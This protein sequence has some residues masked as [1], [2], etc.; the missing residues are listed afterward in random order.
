MNMAGNSAN[1]LPTNPVNVS[2]DNFGMNSVNLPGANSSLINSDS[3]YNP[4][5]T[6]LLLQEKPG[7]LSDGE[8]NYI[9]VPNIPEKVSIGSDAQSGIIISKSRFDYIFI[10]ITLV[11]GFLI[12]GI[13]IGSIVYAFNKTEVVVPPVV[14]S[15]PATEPTS[16]MNVGAAAYPAQQVLSYPIQISNKEVCARNPRTEFRDG[17][18]FCKDPFFGP[19]C[20]QEKHHE[21]FFAVGDA[22]HS[23]L[24]LDIIDEMPAKGKSFTSE[25]CSTFCLENPECKG[26]VYR[27]N[28]NLPTSE[29]ICTLLKEVVVPKNQTI[30]FSADKDSTIYLLS[31]EDLHFEGRV[32]LAA[33]IFDFPT[34]YWLHADSP[35]FTQLRLNEIKKIKFYPTEI[36]AHTNLTGIYCLHEFSYSDIPILLERGTNDQT[37]IHQPRVMLNIPRDWEYKTPI[38]VV[39]I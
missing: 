1:N 16:N 26:F 6:E 29:G 18:C 36:I 13:V 19:N 38:Y 25:S 15:T 34:R 20:E 10:G 30:S 11:F 22:N 8:V 39:Y 5:A 2:Y 32:F 27:K 21:K 12:L 17:E 35:Y 33:T 37:Y 14:E 24:R 4:T 23:K 9:Y 7:I 3:M 31:S 28:K